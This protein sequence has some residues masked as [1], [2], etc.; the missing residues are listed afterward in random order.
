MSN[1]TVAQEDPAG[2][3]DGTELVRVVQGGNSVRTTLNAIIALVSGFISSAV[4]TTK[5][6]LIAGGAAG[7]ASRLG[8]GTNGYYLTPDS[9]QT[10]GMKWAALPAGIVYNPPA[11]NAQTGTAYTLALTDAPAT[12]LSQGIVSMN[13]AAANV[14]TVP[15]NSVV[16]FPVGTVIQVNQLGVGQTTI[17]AT[18]GVTIRTAASLTARTQ[19]SQ[20][21]LTKIG[22]DTWMLSGDMT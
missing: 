17:A 7:V 6:D 3:L 22:T 20:L 15:L 11:Y 18:G 10:L 12:S 8:I 14:L 2:P 13:N 21:L 16:A 1:K 4:M 19:Y 9:T 5:G